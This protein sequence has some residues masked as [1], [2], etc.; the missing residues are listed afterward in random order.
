MDQLVDSFIEFLKQ[1]FLKLS[2][3][4]IFICLENPD[5]GRWI[6]T[7]SPM[8]TFMKAHGY[9]TAF[10]SQLRQNFIDSLLARDGLQA[11]KDLRRWWARTKS[12]VPMFNALVTTLELLLQAKLLCDRRRYLLV[13]QEFREKFLKRSMTVSIYKEYPSRQQKLLK[14][15]ENFSFRHLLTA[16]EK[17]LELN[18]YV[19]PQQSDRYVPDIQTLLETFI[20]NFTARELYEED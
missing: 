17:L 1:H 11:I 4:L 16:M 7:M 10:R 3:V 12:P 13:E 19:F 6:N 5:K 20:L 14:A 15:A 2:N 8:L 18:V 9:V